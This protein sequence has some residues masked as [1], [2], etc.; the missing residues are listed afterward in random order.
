MRHYWILVEVCVVADMLSKHLCKHTLSLTQTH[1]Q[2]LTRTL[3][4]H[5]TL[6][7][8]QITVQRGVGQ[9]DTQESPTVTCERDSERVEIRKET[10]PSE[11]CV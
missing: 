1:M 8:G 3:I 7:G 9:T 6:R 10:V 4:T 5:I 2:P 11:A